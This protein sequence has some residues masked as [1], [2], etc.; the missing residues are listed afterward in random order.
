MLIRYY[1]IVIS[2][3]VNFVSLESSLSA[4]SKL[5]P[6]TNFI[7]APQPEIGIE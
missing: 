3:I 6:R 5:T 4:L 1:D 2:T 7:P